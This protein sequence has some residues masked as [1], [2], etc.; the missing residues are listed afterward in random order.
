MHQL[1]DTHMLIEILRLKKRQ[2]FTFKSTECA[3][4]AKNLTLPNMKPYKAK[5]PNSVY[6]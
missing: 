3:E 2:V 4:C 6:F 1:S 5:I